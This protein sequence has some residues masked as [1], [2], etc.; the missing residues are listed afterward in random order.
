VTAQIDRAAAVRTAL[1]ALVAERGFHGA[2]MS[3]VARQAGVATGTAYTHYDSKDALVLAAY[4]ETKAQLADAVIKTVDEQATVA[5]RFRAIWLGIH[6]YL[7]AHPEHARFL[8][9]FDDSPYRSRAHDALGQD[10]RLLALASA[11]EF[12]AELLPLPLDVLYE[13]GIAT[14]VR[15]AAAGAELSDAELEAVVA[16]CWRAITKPH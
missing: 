6:G 11:P 10:D 8:V 15:L 3:A 7:A 14:A 4:A 1:R 9:Q 12:V 5:E 2:S 16:A 13:L